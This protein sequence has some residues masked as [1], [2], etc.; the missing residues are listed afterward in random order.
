VVRALYLN[1]TGP[2]YRVIRN[3]DMRGLNIGTHLNG[4]AKVAEQDAF[5]AGTSCY[6]LRIFDQSPMG[7]HLDTSPAGGECNYPLSPVNATREPVSIAG[8]NVYGAYFEGKMGYRRDPRSLLLSSLSLSPPPSP[9]HPL[10]SLRSLKVR[11]DTAGT[12]L[13]AL[14]L[15]RCRRLCTW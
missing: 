1:Y 11:W 9:H 7:N 2:L 14:L 10:L 15:A 3:S 5:C 6:T 12:T 8:N 13:T 4:F